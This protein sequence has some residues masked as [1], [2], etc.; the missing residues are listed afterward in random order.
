M[1]WGEGSLHVATSDD[2]CNWRVVL[3]ASGEPLAVAVPR[4][5]QFDSG[6]VEPGPP[7]VLIGDGIVLLY[8]GKNGTA[9]PDPALPPGVYSAGQCLLDPRDPRRL[10]DRTDTWFLRPDHAHEVSGQY[11]AGTTFIEGLVR[12][13]GR[14]LLYFGAADSVVGRLV[15]EVVTAARSAARFGRSRGALPRSS[16]AS[17][18]K[19]GL[20]ER[21]CQFSTWPGRDR[22]AAPGNA[23]LHP[24]VRRAASERQPRAANNE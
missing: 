17:R 19:A 21:C 15:R 2:L 10:L 1:Y 20:K 12:F 13:N 16:A 8:N 23:I 9:D 11:A 6:L 24:P 18:G 14:W 4:P 7:A 3:D 5:R 22:H